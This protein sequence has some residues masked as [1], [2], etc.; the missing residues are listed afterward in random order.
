LL[1]GRGMKK[2]TLLS[3]P[4]LIAALSTAAS[5]Q[6][7]APAPMPAP[8]AAAA[9]KVEANDSINVSPLGLL[10]GNLYVTYEHLWSGGH[11]VIVDAGFGHST[12]EGNAEAHGAAGVGYRWHWRGRQNSGFLGVSLHQ[13]IGSGTVTE[14][15]QT[16]DMAVRST[17]LTANVGKRW[18]LGD[19]N[20]NI[21]L[22]FGLGVGKHTAEAKENTPEAKMAE[23]DM[24]AL[25]ALVPIGWEGELSVGY[26]F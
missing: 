21:T 8:A 5:A 15:D 26:N 13:E 12:G 4:L 19:S 2:F 6:E 17:M 14:N 16:Y 11:G 20:W 24:N 9:A 3:A 1:N 23:E 18:M 10:F 7:A 22:R 25:L